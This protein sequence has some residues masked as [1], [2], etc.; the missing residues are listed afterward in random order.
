ML[1]KQNRLRSNTRIKELRLKGQA[2]SNRRFVLIGLTNGER[3]SRFAFSV[4][5]RIGGAVVRNRIKRLARESVRHCLPSIRGGWDVLCIA[6]PLSRSSRFGEVQQ[7]IVELLDRAHLLVTS[8]SLPLNPNCRSGRTDTTSLQA[9][10]GP[11][12]P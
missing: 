1:K 6:R 8:P 2:W 4:S 12:Q 7:S 9:A 5:R 10:G 11:G 3:S